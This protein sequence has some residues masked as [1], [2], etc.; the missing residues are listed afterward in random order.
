MT[1]PQRLQQAHVPGANTL[2]D[3]RSHSRVDLRLTGRFLAGQSEDREIIT[4][5][6]SCDGAYILSPAPPEPGVPVVCYFDQLGRVA[7]HV[8]R[9][10]PDGFA[11][12][13]QTSPLKRDKLASRLNWLTNRDEPAPPDERISIRQTSAGQTFITLSDGTQL[14]CRQTDISLT[15]A[16][17]EALGALPF[18]GDRVQ[19]E[20]LP[21]EVVRV[22]GRTFAVRY[23]RGAEAAGG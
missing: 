6:V 8:V 18:V 10:G 21:A 1:L 13:F 4:T 12:R 9:T 17:F 16:A 22:E 3:R 14:P 5:N 7:A 15:G 19:T 23:L 20:Y 2:R 11:V